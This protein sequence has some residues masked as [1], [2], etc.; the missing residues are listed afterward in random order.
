MPARNAATNSRRCRRSATAPLRKCPACGALRLKRLVSAP[1]FRLKGTGWYETD[2]KK[3]NKKRLVESGDG[4][5]RRGR[6]RGDKPEKAP[7]G[8]AD[9]P[10]K[11]DKGEKAD[12]GD[13]PAKAGDTTGRQQGQEARA[14]APASPVSDYETAAALPRGGTPRLGPDRRSRS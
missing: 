5:C 6:R 12:K 11:G 13:K 1:Q 4:K 9:K 7:D 2:F 10:D 8:K 14:M 3:D